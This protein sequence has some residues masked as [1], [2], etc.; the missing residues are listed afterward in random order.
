MVN[1]FLSYGAKLAEYRCR[2]VSDIA[3]PVRGVPAIQEGRMGMR[4]FLALGML[5]VCA[6][7]ALSQ[8]LKIGDVLSISVLQ[9]PKL[10]R[11]VIID[12]SGQ[13]AVP[14]AGHIRAAGQT[15]LA[16]ENILKAK[17]KPNYRD[18]NLDV[19]VSLVAI[20]KP[21]LEDDLKPKFYVMGQ[22]LN[23]GTF[24]VRQRT[25]LMQ[26]IARAGGFGPYAA[27]ARIQVRRQVGGIGTT[28]LFNYRA[29]EA[30][31]DLSGDIDVHPGDVIIV[32]ERGL[33]E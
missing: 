27:I 19:T 17:L 13:I 24:V 29:F 6:T 11:Q 4:F 3:L 22:V 26:A 32:P 14:L 10:D 33:L 30:G 5:L 31:N 9:D 18:E 7:A 8:T 28:S 23:P 16:L 15:P 1:D 20:A 21:D 2:T 25:T 12:P